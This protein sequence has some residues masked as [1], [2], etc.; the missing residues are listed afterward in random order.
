MRKISILLAAVSLLAAASLIEVVTAAGAKTVH[1][2]VAKSQ[3]GPRGPRGKTG[4]RGSTG[5]RGRTGRAGPAGPAGGVGPMGPAGKNATDF[6]SFNQLVPF[7]GTESVTIGQFTVSETAGPSGC[8]DAELTDNSAFSAQVNLLGGFEST[9]AGTGFH[10]LAPASQFDIGNLS[11]QILGDL[12]TFTATLANGA[13]TIS[14][15]VGGR[16]LVNGCLTTGTFS[17]A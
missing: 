1:A 16:T 14:G 13:S 5:A 11:F 7:N 9:V 17:G 4:P 15:T 3:R 8:G 10:P 2:T 12:N 6:D